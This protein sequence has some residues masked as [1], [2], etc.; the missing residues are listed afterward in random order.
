MGR[1]RPPSV[2][3]SA[4]ITAAGAKRLKDELTHLWKVERPQVTQTVHEAAKNGDRSENGDYIYGKRRL[5]EIDSRVRF[6]SKRLEVLTVVD[7]LPE[8]Q[9]RVFFG[10]WVTLEDEDGNEHLWQIVGP[11]EFDVSQR[12]L[13]MDSPLAKAM[14]RKQL[15]DEIVLRKPEGEEIYYITA[16][17]YRDYG[18]S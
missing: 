9:S 11:D 8:D 7:R 15:D 5:R 4:Y 18:E 1:W 17:E 2:K 6:L 13:S 3:G 10:A 12:K 16:I 14:L